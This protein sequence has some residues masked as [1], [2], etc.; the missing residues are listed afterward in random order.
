MLIWYHVRMEIKDT[1][2]Y[3]LDVE[4]RELLKTAGF[5]IKVLSSITIGDMG[6]SND[7][8]DVVKD[9]LD[10]S[11]CKHLKTLFWDL[12]EKCRI[13]NKAF[14]PPYEFYSGVTNGIEYQ[15]LLDDK[16]FCIYLLKQEVDHNIKLM[17]LLNEKGFE[18]YS[19]VLNSDANMLTKQ[20]LE[21][22]KIKLDTV[23]KIENRVKGSVA[24]KLKIDSNVTQ[25][26]NITINKA[27]TKSLDNLRKDIIQLEYDL[28]IR[29]KLDIPDN[30]SFNNIDK[31]EFLL[32]EAMKSNNKD[33]IN[34]AVEIEFHKD[35]LSGSTDF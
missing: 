31:P 6:L 16:V 8:E 18:V 26:Q 15:K 19:E 24:Q 28:G 10:Y 14:V 17:S 4:I 12:I 5:D 33:L 32:Q 2:Q 35:N 25:N 29:D 34:K 21:L 13:G 9:R 20:D 7:V 23:A 27:D 3:V 22:M 1:N 11:T 30:V